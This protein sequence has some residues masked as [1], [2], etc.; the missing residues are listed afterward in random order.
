MPYYLL[1]TAIEKKRCVLVK[2]I[3]KSGYLHYVNNYGTHPLTHACCFGDV[4]IVKLLINKYKE[5]ISGCDLI[6]A[7]KHDNADVVELLLDKGVDPNYEVNL[8]L[9]IAAENGNVDIINL[10]I[11]YGAYVGINSSVLLTAASNYNIE[12]TKLIIKNIQC[13]CCRKR[14]R[15]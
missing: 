9:H 1:L 6:D 13:N 11:K 12:A 5:N 4:K 10:L 14:K 7:C 2:Y 15:S 8:P 3:L